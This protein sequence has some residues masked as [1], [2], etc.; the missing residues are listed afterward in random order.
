MSCLS[1]FNIPVTQKYNFLGQHIQIVIS[2]KPILEQILC[3][4]IQ[5]QR[6]RELYDGMLCS[7]TFSSKESKIKMLVFKTY[8]AIHIRN[9]LKMTSQSKHFKISA[10]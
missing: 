8:R 5:C 3:Q 10:N 1:G 7:R 4:V 2:L 6:Y 9:F